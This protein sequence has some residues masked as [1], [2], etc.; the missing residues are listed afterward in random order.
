MHYNWHR[1]YDPSLGRYTQHDTLGFVDGPSVYGYVRNNPYRYV[2]PDS[3][4]AQVCAANPGACTTVI[5]KTVEACLAV[6]TYIINQM[7][8]KKEGFCSCS[9]RDRNKVGNEEWA[10]LRLRN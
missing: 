2:D 9:H 4:A 6:G 5:K 7:S 10:C 3:R 1:H 8:K